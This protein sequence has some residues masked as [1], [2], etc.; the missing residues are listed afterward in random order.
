MLK[1]IRIHGRGGQGNV[2]ASEFM[3]DAAFEDG[4]YLTIID[5]VERRSLDEP[6]RLTED[7]QLVFIRLTFLAGA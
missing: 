5:G 4:L 2:T 7:S 3:A 1:E 6:V